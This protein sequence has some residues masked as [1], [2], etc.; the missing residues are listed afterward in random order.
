MQMTG[1]QPSMINSGTNNGHML[2]L[3]EASALLPSSQQVLIGSAPPRVDASRNTDMHPTLLH[4]RPIMVQ[5]QG[6]RLPS[7]SRGNRNSDKSFFLHSF[8]SHFERLSVRR[9][10]S[11][12]RQSLD[13]VAGVFHHLGRSV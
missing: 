9:K 7:N 2:M 5:I 13:I 4:D 8:Y 12:S 11:I 10:V 1:E 3:N 6:V